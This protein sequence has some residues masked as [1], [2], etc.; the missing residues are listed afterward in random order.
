VSVPHGLGPPRRVTDEWRRAARALGVDGRAYA[1]RWRDL[2]E[3]AVLQ[4]RGLGPPREVDLELVEAYVRHRRLADFHRHF[5]ESEPYHSKPSGIVHAHPGWGMAQREER[6][7]AHAAGV[8][9]IHAREVEPEEPSANGHVDEEEL[10]GAVND[11]QLGPDGQ[12]L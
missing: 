9:G 1:Q 5:A 12:P 4:A 6:L 10:V 7:A 8:L 2:W 3:R 11:D